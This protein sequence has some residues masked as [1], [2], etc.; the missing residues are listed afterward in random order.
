MAETAEP[1]LI[2]RVLQRP[3]C[4]ASIYATFGRHD[5]SKEFHPKVR[6][7]IRFEPGTI[8]IASQ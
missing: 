5:V 3:R 7:P 8:R 2:H 6:A 4:E 1:I